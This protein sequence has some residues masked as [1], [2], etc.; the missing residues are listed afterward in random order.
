MDKRSRKERMLGKQ[1]LSLVF[2][3]PGLSNI[4]LLLTVIS[5]MPNVNKCAWLV[6]VEPTACGNHYLCEFIKLKN[7]TLG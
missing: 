6:L 3:Y 2:S 1:N 5:N 7:F 4:F